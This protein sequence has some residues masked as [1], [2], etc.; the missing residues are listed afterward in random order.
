MTLDPQSAAKAFTNL[1]I[2]LGKMRGIAGHPLNY[3]LCSNLK[4]PN[5]ADVDNETKDPP[6]LANQGALISLLMTTFAAGPQYCILT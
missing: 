3:V 1:L 6:L 4:G 5:N 2:L